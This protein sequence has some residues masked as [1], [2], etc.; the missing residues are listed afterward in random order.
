MIWFSGCSITHNCFSEMN[1]DSPS[2]YILFKKLRN[3]F[4]ILE[5]VLFNKIVNK[6]S[7]S[8]KKMREKKWIKEISLKVLS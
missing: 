7:I 2:T 6:K 4:Q 8:R 5:M 3:M 1:I